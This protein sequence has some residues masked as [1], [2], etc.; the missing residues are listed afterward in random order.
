MCVCVCARARVYT[1]ICI[2]VCVCVCTYIYIYTYIKLVN[3]LTHTFNNLLN[4]SHKIH[5]QHN[6]QCTEMLQN[7]RSRP[8]YSTQTYR[9]LLYSLMT[10][11]VKGTCDHFWVGS[12][13]FNLPIFDKTPVL[14][15]QPDHNTTSI[16]QC[17]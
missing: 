17:T 9:L 10:T 7:L 6:G 15:R 3:L 8:H 14:N 13:N 12:S 4:V 5:R 11:M 1:Y 16:K 2:C